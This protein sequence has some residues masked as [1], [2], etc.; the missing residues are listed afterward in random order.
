[1]ADRVLIEVVSQSE[2]LDETNAK[3]QELTQRE[4][5]LIAQMDGLTKQKQ[6]WQGS[7]VAVAAFDKEI[8][9]TNTELKSAR[10]SIDELSNAT[11]AMPGKVVAEQAN[12][13]FRNLRREI[14]EQIKQLRL[15][16]KT[17]TEEYQRLIEQAGEL[18]NVQKN[19]SKEISNMGSNTPVF[20]AIFSGTQLIAGGFSVAQGTAALF[21]A[22]SEDLQKVMVKLQGVIAI[23]TGL[24]GAYNAVRKEGA[25]MQSV[26]NFQKMAAVKAETLKAAA[27]ASGTK[28]TLGATIAQ[29]AW[30][31]AASVNPYVLLAMAI[32]SVVGAIA[33][34]SSGA[35]DASEKSKKYKSTTDDLRFA[36]KEARDE[37][38]KFNQSVRDIQ[39]EIDLATGAI[40]QYG[41][42]MKKIANDAAD[43]MAEIDKKVEEENK[44]IIDNYNSFGHALGVTFKNSWKIWQSPGQALLEDE[45]K[46]N[47]K[48]LENQK[49][50]NEE[51]EGVQKIA[52][53]KRKAQNAKT[54]EEILRQ[55]EDM[56]NENTK[57]LQGSL[58]KI[59]TAR[60]RALEEAKKTNEDRIANEQSTAIDLDEINK[61]YD[62]QRDEA[63]K[64]ESDKIKQEQ[65]KLNSEIKQKQDKRNSEIV[66]AEQDLQ[67]EK[68][69]AM[70]DGA[71]KEIATIKQ[72]LDIRL[73]E[74][75]GDS[76]AEIDL[77]V[78]MEENAQKEVKKIEE[79]YQSDRQKSM[80]ETEI[81]IT[82]AQLAEV[83][84]GSNEELSLRQQLLQEKAKLDESD[85][86]NSVNS[87]E[88]KAAKIK[89]INANLNKDLKDLSEEYI[90]TAQD[91][92][93]REVLAVT[94]Q[95]EQ[96]KIS[97]SDYEKQLSDISIKS[98]EDE[99]KERKA[100]GQDTI[101]LEKD[102]SEKRIAIAEQE[103]EYRKQL[104]SEL[105]NTMGEIGNSFFD[106]Q[107]Q[108]LD[109]QLEDLHH[110]YTTD[111]EEAKKNK[112]MQLISEQEMAQRQLDIKRK[113]AK[114]EKDQAIFNATINGIVAVVNALSTQPVWLGI[115]MAALIGATVA[116]QIAAI[117]AK[118][119][120]KYWK[121][122]RGG[123]GEYAMF[124]EYGPELA[125]IP[126][127]ASLMPAHE[128]RRAMM[129]DNK[130]F[131]RWNMPPIEPKFIAP[132]INHKLVSQVLE[133]QS[134][135]ERLLLNIDYDKLG[136]AVAKHAKYPKQKDVSINFDK[137]GLSVTEGNTTTHVLNAK[138]NR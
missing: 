104:F 101:D 56:H 6:Q 33:I 85:V 57:G 52:D 128:T 74:I 3:L 69:K 86:Q 8:E 55:N 81:A 111:A 116:V 64:A 34:F 77:R 92:S 7:A 113:Q 46:T 70:E 78:Q 66:K 11:K 13:S 17:G 132:S 14:E 39:I 108:N 20:D 119:L 58:D 127:G 60:K 88:W 48:I 105:F 67:T 76:Q 131:D 62:N 63:I 96:G 126:A 68:I 10:K 9:K 123:K 36:T 45:K 73:A 49:K 40:S 125:W 84:K 121:G 42:A 93:K 30:N 120:P 124:G 2:G 47:D 122:R 98:L 110:Y 82:N 4:K 89:E 95:Y 79:K 117:N 5:E 91:R 32:I 25:I 114:A 99:I 23:S 65:D 102:L 80:M 97:K 109:Q 83:E 26:E 37:H 134:R 24:Q 16:G 115:V 129:G 100:K 51:K 12:Q 31:L 41:A 43:A 54:N 61:K 130:A 28:A 44:K 50:G 27:T 1:M 103:A 71:N 112:D 137:S 35:D 138:Y 21:G 53:D 107:K 29:K 19:V 106:I 90:Q 118:P 133:R 22:E 87:E 135:E 94:Q 38:D 18:A 72:N 75:K 59:E 136:R 15:A